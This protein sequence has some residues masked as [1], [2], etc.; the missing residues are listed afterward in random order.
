MKE[1]PAI[2]D[3]IISMS[4]PVAPTHKAMPEAWR[5]KKDALFTLSKMKTIIVILL[6]LIFPLI[7]FAQIPEIKWQNCFGTNEWD[8]TYGITEKENGYL[9]AIYIPCN[10]QGISNYHG[11]GEAWIVNID[12]N[13]NVI[14][15][16]CFGGSESEDVIKI[17]KV[18]NY[19]FYLVGT[20]ESSDYDITCD[21]NYGSTDFWV[22]KINGNGDIL[23]DHCYGSIATDEM[24]DAV[25]TP[26]GGLLFMGRIF[27]NGG[28]VHNWYGSYDVWFCKIDSLGTIEWEKT[29][30]NQAIDNGISMQLISD[31]SFAFIGGYYEPG[32]MNDCEIPITGDGADLWLV[33]MSLLDGD[34]LNI[35]CYGGSSND[36]GYYFDK[37]DDG[38]ILIS[39]T[40]SWDGDITGFHGEQ[41]I[42]IV[43]IDDDGG[44]V[45]QRCLGGSFY[46]TPY[47]VSQVDD[48]G[49][50]V[51]GNTSSHNGDVTN[52]HSWTQGL[53]IWVV[54]LSSTGEIIWDQCYGGLDDERFFG[55][56][57]I[58]KKDD[59]NYVFNAQAQ[60][61]SVDV[62][63]ELHGER[64]SW[65]FEIDSLDTTGVV[66]SHYDKELMKVYPNPAKDYVEFEL[67]SPLI[68]PQG[69]SYP[70]I[71]VNN[72]FG[73]EV[74]MLP[75]KRERTVWDCRDI[76]QGIY[77]YKI[78][79]KGLTVAGKIV[80][81]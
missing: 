73:Q 68:P 32:G 11:E 3:K 6:Y 27:Y 28:D 43:R 18:S 13:G 47:F 75:V 62:Q 23:W 76:E 19:E 50:V 78:E 10:G 21:T 15:E 2:S 24:R 64:D 16:K 12:D 39:S 54:K 37:L 56:H 22:L 41:D 63:C 45:W 44:I 58:L 79:I 67:T 30:G 46:E 74:A 55:T 29:V 81:K 53:D 65:V 17:I 7:S 20:T 1:A 31:T 77:I 26:D 57:S 66:A 34:I 60:F 4:A 40:T 70:V 42:W 52:N 51:I 71:K 33:E 36:L 69:G 8:M 38:Y 61:N 35:Y 49:F 48:G 59:Y 9:L 25:L 80:I 14:W 5:Q 72:I